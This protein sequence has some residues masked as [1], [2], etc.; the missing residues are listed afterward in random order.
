MKSMDLREVKRLASERNADP[1]T[2]LYAMKNGTL[3]N[4][5]KHEEIPTR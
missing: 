4:V 2:I 3:D 5:R 1:I